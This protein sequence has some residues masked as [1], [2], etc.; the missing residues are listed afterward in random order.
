[1]KTWQLNGK[2]EVTTQAN[3][4]AAAPLPEYVQAKE[5]EML[6]KATEQKFANSRLFME[7]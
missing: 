4:L 1:L 7:I 5:P 3:N 2:N 6:W